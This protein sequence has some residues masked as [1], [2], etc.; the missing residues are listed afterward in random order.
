MS[1][2]LE[3]QHPSFSEYSGLISF[4]IDWFNLLAVQGSVKSLLQHQNLK[5]SVLHLPAFF[6]VQLSH[7]Y[8]TAGKTIALTIRTFVGKVVSLLLNK[9]FRFVIVF[10]PRSKH[11]II[12]WLQSVLAV[13]FQPKKIKSVVV[14]IVSPSISL[15][16]L[17]LDAM[18][19]AF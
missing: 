18:I 9:F 14:S 5:A 7:P 8:M 3:L 10:L 12:S 4:R 15:E 6:I 1:T 17:G 16:V 2:V 19:L 13:I 11:L